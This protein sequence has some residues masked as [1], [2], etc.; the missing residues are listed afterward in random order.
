VEKKEYPPH[1][2][3]LKEDND[4]AEY[5]SL[6][7]EYWL[8][9]NPVANQVFITDVSVNSKSVTIRECKTEKGFFKERELKSDTSDNPV[10]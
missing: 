1:R 9:R 8:A 2:G 5:T 3:S 6:S 4:Y 7:S 10:V